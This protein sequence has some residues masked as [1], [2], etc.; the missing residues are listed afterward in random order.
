MTY[1][2]EWAKGIVGFNGLGMQKAAIARNFGQLLDT[3]LG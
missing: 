3:I 1:A 2:G